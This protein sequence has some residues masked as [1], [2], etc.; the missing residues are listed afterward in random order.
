MVMR[1][2]YG[3]ALQ[4]HERTNCLTKM[5]K[6]PIIFLTFSVALRLNFPENDA[7]FGSIYISV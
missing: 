6:V 4:A 7:Q 3:L 1:V 5:L 2:Y